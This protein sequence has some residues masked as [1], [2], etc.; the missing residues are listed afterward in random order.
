M[1]FDSFILLV[2]AEGIINTN[3][4]HKTL[5]LDTHKISYNY[6]TFNLSTY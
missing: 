4:K 3:I 2:N 1:N 5:Q 6:F